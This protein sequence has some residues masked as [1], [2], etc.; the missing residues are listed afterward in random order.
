MR[1]RRPPR[2][3]RPLNAKNEINVKACSEIQLSVIRAMGHSLG[4][5]AR[6]LDLGCGRGAL[7][8]EYRDK[9]YD[10]PALYL[11]AAKTAQI[12][13]RYLRGN[14]NYLPKG[15]IRRRVME[16]F[17]NC[18]FCEEAFLLSAHGGLSPSSSGRFPSFPG[19]TAP[20]ERA[21]C[22]LQKSNL[23]LELE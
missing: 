4:P 15:E 1:K 13:Y 21:P 18:R 5:G 11:P 23:L 14:A 19:S 12:N 16:Q 10:V 22:S 9:G 3:L 20:C 17:G 8:K 7:V 6:V 2:P